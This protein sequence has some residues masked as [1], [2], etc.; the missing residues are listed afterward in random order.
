VN[1]ASRQIILVGAGLSN[2]LLADRLLALKPDLDL[3]VLEGGDAPGGNHTWCFH[4]SDVEPSAMAWLD[5]YVSARWQQHDVAFPSFART[6]PGTYLAIRSEDFAKRVTERLG[7][8]LKL[9]TRVKTVRANSVVLDDGTE[10]QARAVI[11]GRGGM[12]GDELA[13]GY[14]KFLGQELRLTAPHGLARPMLMDASVPQLD[15]FRFVYV[16]PWDE[17]TVLVED[18]RYSDTPDIDAPAFR[19]EIARY[20]QAR[21]WQVEAVVRE[22]LAA[23][24]IPLSG[25]LPVQHRPVIGVQGGFFHATTGY[26]VPFAVELAEVLA[27]LPSLD[28][29]VITRVLGERARHH[30]Q[31]MGFFRVLNRMLFRGA[32]PAGRVTVFESFYRHSPE[33]I[34]RFYAGRLTWADKLQALRRGAPTVPAGRAMRAALFG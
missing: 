13:C 12:M 11:D 23:L 2:G 5:P 4:D 24:P 27:R 15:G 34:A 26:S 16:L 21:G 14:Q 6:L 19:D 28:A 17:R 33:L 31:A 25:E 22:E 8:R 1:P 3:L 32:E 20:V 9:R 7:E 29:A 10:L 30:W 18:T